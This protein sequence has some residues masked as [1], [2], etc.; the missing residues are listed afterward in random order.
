MNKPTLCDRCNNAPFCLLNFDGKP[1][2]KVRTVEPTNYDLLISKTPEGLAKWM[3]WYGNNG[4]TC[5]FED[6]DIVECGYGPEY[7]S[8]IDWLKSPVEEGEG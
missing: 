5:K 1:C 3:V 6:F 4:I 2:R 8:A 7:D